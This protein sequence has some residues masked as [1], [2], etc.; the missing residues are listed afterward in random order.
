MKKLKV[1]PSKQFY[2]IGRIIS[3]GF[4]ASIQATKLKETDYKAKYIIKHKVFAPGYE[5]VTDAVYSFESVRNYF[6]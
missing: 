2:N 4:I 3:Y 1:S 6:D 5:P